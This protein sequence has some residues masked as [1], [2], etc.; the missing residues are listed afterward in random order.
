[1]KQCFVAAALAGLMLICSMA[2]AGPTPAFAGTYNG[3]L[4]WKTYDM[5]T[6]AKSSGKQTVVLIIN[7]NSTYT[8]G[9]NNFATFAGAGHFGT[10]VG[11]MHYQDVNHE[12]HS[13]LHFKGTSAKGAF[14]DTSLSGISVMEGKLSL[15]KQ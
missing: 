6:G 14:L 12:M 11:S 3:T 15:K 13:T 8:M 9:I 2:V 7:A 1:M 5:S 4:S 10:S